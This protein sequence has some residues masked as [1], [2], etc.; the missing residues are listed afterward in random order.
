[1]QFVGF[2]LKKRMASRQKV[3]LKEELVQEFGIS[4][5]SEKKIIKAH[6]P[7]IYIVP[8]KHQKGLC[9]PPP[10]PARAHTWSVSRKLTTLWETET[11][12][13][14]QHS[15]AKLQTWHGWNQWE[16][17]RPST[18]G[19]PIWSHSQDSVV[20]QGSFLPLHEAPNRHHTSK[21]RM[22]DKQKPK[23]FHLHL[24]SSLAHSFW[25]AWYAGRKITLRTR[26]TPPN[27]GHASVRL[28]TVMKSNA[29]F[30]PTEV[31]A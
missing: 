25:Q 13:L 23:K 31:E 6:N 2:K 12:G 21:W 19:G 17:C 24:Q 3:G 5:N 30:W 1:M 27:T 26:D 7:K 11:H 28:L 10:A 16:W 18:P 9:V 22:T 15:V 20:G 14:Q 29:V 4:E 8:K